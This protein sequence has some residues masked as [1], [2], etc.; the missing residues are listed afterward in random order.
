MGIGQWQVL[1]VIAKMMR[2]GTQENDRKA[3]KET[4]RK[5]VR[6]RH[7]NQKT[8]RKR[9]S[10][11]FLHRQ[12]ASQRLRLTEPQY[13]CFTM[14][15]FLIRTAPTFSGIFSLWSTRSGLSSRDMTLSQ[16]QFLQP[17]E[18]GL[19]YIYIRIDTI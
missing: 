1:E 6:K 8:S 4:N 3:A 14:V 16:V 18:I 7:K 10:L 2:K 9:Q 17:N 13:Q 12:N 11:P 5:T 19:E 15:Y